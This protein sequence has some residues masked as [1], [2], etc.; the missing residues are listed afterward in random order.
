MIASFGLTQH[1]GLQENIKDH[2]FSTRTVYLNSVFSFLYWHMEYHIEH[3]MFPSVPSYNLPKLHELIKNQ[4]PPPRQGLWGAYKEII[5]ALIKQ[6][7]DA[8]YKI[9]LILKMN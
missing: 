7:K 4:L 5:P 3:H 1:T 6:S 8:K 9:P 2:R